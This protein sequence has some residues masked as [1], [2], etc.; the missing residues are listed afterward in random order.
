MP[1]HVQSNFTLILPFDSYYDYSTMTLIIHTR[2]CSTCI[3]NM[4]LIM[5]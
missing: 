1:T 2:H 3:I 5:Y 4:L